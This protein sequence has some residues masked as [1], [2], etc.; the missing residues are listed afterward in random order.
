MHHGAKIST[1]SPLIDTSA[2][3]VTLRQCS[4]TRVFYQIS[5]G[6]QAGIYNNGDI[7][8]DSIIIPEQKPRQE[9]G[10]PFRDRQRRP[11][12]G[13]VVRASAGRGPGEIAANQTNN[14]VLCQSTY[15]EHLVV[16]CISAPIYCQ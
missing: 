5:T 13:P 11:W 10:T 8:C 2:V 14:T 16:T 7:V 9:A 15:G 6:A 1:S 3:P 12:S 4:E